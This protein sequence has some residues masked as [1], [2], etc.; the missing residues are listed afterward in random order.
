MWQEHEFSEEYGAETVRV[1]LASLR[2]HPLFRLSFGPQ[3]LPTVS[4]MKP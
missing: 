1:S 4:L 2:E 3:A